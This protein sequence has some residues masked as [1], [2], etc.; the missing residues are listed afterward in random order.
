MNDVFEKYTSKSEKLSGL[1]EERLKLLQ[2]KPTEIPSTCHLF[3]WF[4]SFVYFQHLHKIHINTSI[5]NIW[6]VQN[7]AIQ[8]TWAQPIHVVFDIMCLMYT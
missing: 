1:S 8:S 5:Y 2:L 6:Q 7:L 4:H 3:I